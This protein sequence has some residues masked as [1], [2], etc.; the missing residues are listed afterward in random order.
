MKS[1]GFFYREYKKKE[2]SVNR[3][4]IS[5]IFSY[6]PV[7]YIKETSFVYQGKSCARIQPY[8]RRR[9]ETVSL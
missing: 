6:L 3:R 2:I 7:Y 9:G 1:F 5:M 8:K 4:I